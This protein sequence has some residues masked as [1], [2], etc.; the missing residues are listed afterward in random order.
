ML[1]E[2]DLHHCLFFSNHASNYLPIRARLPKDKES[3]L[4]L[5]DEVLDAGNT[6]FLKPEHLRAL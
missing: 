4:Q 5:I 2:S 3:S 1:A 6:S